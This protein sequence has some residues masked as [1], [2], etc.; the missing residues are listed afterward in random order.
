MEKL[1]LFFL[2]DIVGFRYWIILLF[3]FILACGKNKEIENTAPVTPIAEKKTSNNPLV[4][5]RDRAVDEIVK[6]FMAKAS[7]VGLSVGIL[8]DGQISYYGYGIIAKNSKQIPDENTAFEIG[9]IS[10]TFTAALAVKF[11]ED[12]GLTIE[13][14]IA[15]WL[16]KTV[17][18]LS[19]NGEQIKF[20]HLMNHTS[21]LPRLPDDIYVGTNPKDPYRLYDTVRLYNYLKTATLATTPG[22]TYL[23]SNL[24]YGILG[25]IIERNT[26]QTYSNY[27]R[28]VIGNPLVLTRT[29]SMT[30]DYSQN[31]SHGYDGT[32]SETSYW[33]GL[34]QGAFKGAGT[35]YSSAKDLI[36]YATYQTNYSTEVGKL[37][38]ETQKVSWQSGNIKIGLAWRY[39]TIN[40]LECIAHDGLTSGY[41]AYLI[42][43]RSKN[44]AVAILSNN[45]DDDLDQ[46]FSQFSKTF[47]K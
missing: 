23:Y 42:I 7:S 14:P 17:P 28:E 22:K 29:Y 32:G 12:R 4:T 31:L 46:I 37:F 1:T 33:D 25:T 21:G 9:S 15:P 38:A 39:T 41:K 20:K 30:S 45:V 36:R 27:F 43:C 26:Q 11:M 44:I 35:L 2:R 6:P 16:P 47:I 5:E 34:D 10:K 40:G 8:K 13:S 3:P 24:A 19:L 18:T